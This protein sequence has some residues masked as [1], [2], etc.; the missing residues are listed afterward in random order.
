[1]RLRTLAAATAAAAAT[2]GAAGPASPGAAEQVVPI[3]MY[4]VVAAPPADAPY[5]ELYVRPADFSRQLDW[6][7]GRGFQAVTLQRVVD[8]WHGTAGLPRRPI[9]IS[10][11]D[12]YR[13]QFVNAFPALRRRRWPG[14]LNLAIRNLKPSWGISAR[15]VRTL[16]RA[17]WE[18]DSH[19]ID[20]PDLTAVE[21]EALR[22]QVA[23]S[24]AYL[25]R[26]FGV[27]ANFF[28]YPAG[29]YD[30]TV[31]AAV[32]AAGYGGATTTEPGLAEPSELWELDRVRVSGSDGV[33]GLAAKIRSLVGA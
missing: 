31:M 23:A 11:D 13:S 30:E 24:R 17:G 20:H 27:P 25:R 19:T 4:H 1:V 15:R 16:V 8:S 3:L 6:L 9:V 22:R 7:A 32:R 29:R 10:F 21:P 5:P 28:C 26:V 18:I 14:V 2:F 12:G 33:E